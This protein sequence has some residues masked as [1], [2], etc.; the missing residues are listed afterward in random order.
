MARSGKTLRRNEWHPDLKHIHLLMSTPGVDINAD[1]DTIATVPLIG[2]IRREAVGTVRKL[3]KAKADP[4]AW[5]PGG[6]PGR[7]SA[8]VVAL[9]NGSKQSVEIVELLLQHQADPNTITGF[10]APLRVVCNY[11]AHSLAKAELLLAYKA[12]P[13]GFGQHCWSTPL[14][15][16][17]NGY[18]RISVDAIKLLIANKAS[19]ELAHNHTTPL[20][21]ACLREHSKAVSVLLAAGAR[22]DGDL[23]PAVSASM[24]EKLAWMT[25]GWRPHRHN[26]S[27]P[28]IMCVV[29][30]MMA[31]RTIPGTVV[32]ILPNELLFVIFGLLPRVPSFDDPL[33]VDEM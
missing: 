12:D 9:Q 10:G 24:R 23:P 14:L 11:F 33:F 22:Y 1:D 29:R 6:P 28:E 27:S 8:L 17:I 5:S 15:Q 31:L 4:N 20:Q 2:A 3:L 21:A 7:L 30:T 32:C 13:D 16:S 25:E 26:D 18:K 19:V